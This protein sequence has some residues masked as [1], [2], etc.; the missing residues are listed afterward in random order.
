VEGATTIISSLTVGQST[1]LPA[2]NVTETPSHSSADH[3]ARCLVHGFEHHEF[4]GREVASQFGGCVL[5][6]VVGL[7]ALPFHD[8]V[9]V[10]FEGAPTNLGEGVHVSV[11]DGLNGD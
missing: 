10:L 6:H 2:T 3:G 1:T 7:L 4:L 9:A 8:R 11:G 5:V